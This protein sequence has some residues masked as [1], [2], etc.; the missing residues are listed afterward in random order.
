MGYTSLLVGAS[1]SSLLTS[2]L[3]PFLSLLQQN[4]KKTFTF[5]SP[6]LENPFSHNHTS[7]GLHPRS[8]P[9]LC[10]LLLV[11]RTPSHWQPHCLSNTSAED[12]CSQLQLQPTNHLSTHFS[13]SR[14][15]WPLPETLSRTISI[16]STF[17]QLHPCAS[18]SFQ[19]SQ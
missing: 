16:H 8:T 15:P 5:R 6:P 1:C 13:C 3:F 2:L 9:T 17:L 10:S 12:K 11:W 14:S 7:T 18:P 19:V 4:L